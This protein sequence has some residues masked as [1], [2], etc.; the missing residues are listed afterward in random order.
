MLAQTPGFALRWI[1]YISAAAV[2]VQLLLNLLLL[3]REFRLRLG[4]FALPQDPGLR[5]QQV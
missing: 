5:A 2:L 3:K 1:W 4:G